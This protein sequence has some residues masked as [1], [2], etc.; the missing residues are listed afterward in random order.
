MK[1]S[2]DGIKTITN[3]TFGKIYLYIGVFFEK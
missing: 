2:L 3:A 1:L